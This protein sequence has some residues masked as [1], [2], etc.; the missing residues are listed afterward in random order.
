MRRLYFYEILKNLNKY[1]LFL[2]YSWVQF[3]FLI[4]LVFVN[5]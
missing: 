3:I 1:T 4:I 5:N 2:V